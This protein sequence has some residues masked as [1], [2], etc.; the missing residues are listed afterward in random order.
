MILARA[1]TGRSLAG[2]L[3]LAWSILAFGTP[4]ANAQPLPMNGNFSQGGTPPAGWAV[5]AALAGKGAVSVAAGPPNVAGRT[6]V[7][8]PN[9]RNVAGDQPFGVGQLLPANAQ[10]GREV[11]VS[12]ILG[13]DGGARAVLGLGILRQG[14]GASQ[15]QLRSEGPPTAKQ[16]QLTVPDDPAVLGVV[17]YLVVEGTQ[18][19]AKFANVS[20]TIGTPAPAPAPPAATPNRAQAPPSTQGAPIAA[21]VRIDTTRIVRTIP[22]ALFGTNIEVIRNANGLWDERNNRLDPQIVALARDLALGPIRF[23]GGVWSDAYDWQHGIG[24]RNARATTPTHPGAT[25]TYRHTFGTDEGLSFAKEVGSQLLITVNAATGTPKLAADWVRYVNGEGGRAHR[26]QR[27]EWWQIGNELY[28]E[29][30][31]SGGHLSPQAYAEKLLAFSAAMKAVDPTIRIGAIGLRNYDRYRLNRYD[32]WN[33]VVLRRA[34]PAFDMLMVHNAYAPAIGDDAS[35]DAA[36]VYAALLAAPQLI[37]RNLADT[38]QEIERFAPQHAAR[39]QLGITEWGPLYT[40]TI[41]SPWIDH[42]KTLGSAIFVADV[43]RVFAEQPHVG[44]ANF[45][46]LNEASFM[47]WIGRR[48]TTW[49]PTAPYLA[50]R[51]VSRDMEPGLL[52]N[53][54]TVPTYASR[55]I[56]FVDQ[57]AAVPYLG[58]LATA[59]ADGRTVTALLINRSLTS[60]VTAR[61][62]LA[63]TTGATKLVTQTLTGATMDANTGTELP[64]IPGLNWVAQR[65]AGLQGRFDRGGPGEVVLDRKEQANPRGDVEVTVPPHSLT[66]LRFEGLTRP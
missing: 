15:V 56:G 44:L 20:V 30:D 26:G 23:P 65:S 62:N 51:M 53:T 2:L 46:K 16:A 21:T 18:G 47:G 4:P 25:E 36:D 10:R 50:F 55:A 59:A 38:W 14:G 58:V 24:P 9:A 42:V 43:L 13:A 11:T 27:V 54:V 17:I 45:F 28:M 34:A 39:L 1:I 52:A 22:R 57:V 19:A 60:S 61:V 66:L 63:G 3:L 32:D 35:P 41:T 64:R 12:A 49:T 33:E 29:G 40:V 6:L 48:G 8:T 37:A 5:E 31:A 7:L